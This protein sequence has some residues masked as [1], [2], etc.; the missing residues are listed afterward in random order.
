MAKLKR[1]CPKDKHLAALE[2]KMVAKIGVGSR[3]AEEARAK[4]RALKK[5]VL[6]EKQRRLEKDAGSAPAALKPSFGDHLPADTKTTPTRDDSVST[7]AAAGSRRT[8]TPVPAAA[9]AYTPPGPAAAASGPDVATVDSVSTVAT[10][11]TRR[12]GALVPAAARAYTPPGPAAAAS[13]PDVAEQQPTKHPSSNELLLLAPSGSVCND[14]S[15]NEC[16]SLVSY[17]YKSLFR[18]CGPVLESHRHRC[19]P[20]QTV[21]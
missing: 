20:E 7:V 19:Q 6:E 17:L 8:G 2:E 5:S 13:G 1:A 18:S 21:A 4:A 11:G 9:R 16:L 10:T 14:T 15:P 3:A 12:A